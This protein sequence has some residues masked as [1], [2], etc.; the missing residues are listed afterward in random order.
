M[1]HSVSFIF[2]LMDDDFNVRLLQSMVWIVAWC[3]NFWD[4]LD[5]AH[6]LVDIQQATEDEDQLGFILNYQLSF[7]PY[8]DFSVV[9]FLTVLF[10][11]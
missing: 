4:E 9:T 10:G 3:P 1:I 6:N 7:Y 8:F 2:F 5:H 11:T